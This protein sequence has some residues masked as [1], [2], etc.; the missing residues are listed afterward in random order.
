M[1]ISYFHP[2]AGRAGRDQRPGR[3]T[4]L[5]NRSLENGR[6]CCRVLATR[7][8][9]KGTVESEIETCGAYAVMTLPPDT[10][11][12]AAVSDVGQCL[13]VAGGSSATIVGRAVSRSVSAVFS[14]TALNELVD[15]MLQAKLILANYHRWRAGAWRWYASGDQF[16]GV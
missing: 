3:Q 14:G 5:R 10:A 11:R 1:Y 9:P 7:V 12:V 6:W 8:P 15:G 16:F 13:V 2:P 4:A